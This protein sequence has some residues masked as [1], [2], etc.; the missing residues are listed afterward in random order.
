MPGIV[1]LSAFVATAA[2][3][4]GDS[5]NTGEARAPI[6]FELPYVHYTL[7]NGLEVVLHEDHSDPIVAVATIMHV[8]SSRERPG[9]T[10]FA[11][12]FEHVSFNDSENVPVGA[13]RKLIPEL[14]GTRNGGTNPAD[15]FG[16]LVE[17]FGERKRFFAFKF[18]K[19]L[20][21]NILTVF[22]RL[23]STAV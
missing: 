8:G 15:T 7:D 14:G 1:A 20:P 9:R 12:F 5:G 13:N 18:C 21:V 16:G 10:G 19:Q 11:H 23:A 17:F 3:A 2:C 22:F 6:A 4:P